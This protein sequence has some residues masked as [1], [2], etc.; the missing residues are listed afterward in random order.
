[1]EINYEPLFEVETYVR[2]TTEVPKIRFSTRPTLIARMSSTHYRGTAVEINEY[3]R[4]RVDGFVFGHSLRK[5]EQ[6]A[7]HGEHYLYGTVDRGWC[8]DSNRYRLANCPPVF[9]YKC[10]Q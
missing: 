3:G 6:R 1:L 5:D 8:S 2:N 10:F 4:I 9:D 7:F